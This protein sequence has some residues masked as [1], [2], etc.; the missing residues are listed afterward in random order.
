MSVLEPAPLEIVVSVGDSSDRTAEL[1]AAHGAKVVTGHRGRSKQLNDGAAHATGDV[2]VFLHAD[3]N[4]P[5]DAVEVAVRTLAKDE[6]V[7]LGGFVPLI[8]VPNKTFWAM[9]LHNVLK[10][11]YCPLLFQPVSFVKG[12]RLLFG[13]QAMF[14]RAVDFGYVGEG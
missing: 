12:L 5:T 9:S 11:F 7:V 8:S 4:V 3:T 14:C 10:T 13:D 2:L 6:Q 1:A